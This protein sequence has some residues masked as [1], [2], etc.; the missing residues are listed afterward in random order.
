[1]LPRFRFILIGLILVIVYELYLIWYY[2][3][4]D[5]QVWAYMSQL[6]AKNTEIKNRIEAKKAYYAYIRT[7]AYITRM[8]KANLGKK[9]PGENVINIVSEEDAAQN[10]D[11]NT[12]NQINNAEKQESSPTRRMSNPEKWMY[13]LFNV[14]MVVGKE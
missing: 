14:K 6:E 7:E 8:A 5:L 9:L 12:I 13:Y 4:Q 1:M 3:Y 2:K 10:A 11:I